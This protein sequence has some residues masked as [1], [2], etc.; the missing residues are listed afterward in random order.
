MEEKVTLDH[1]LA[2]SQ[3]V[4]FLLTSGARGADTAK[5]LEYLVRK[6]NEKDKEKPQKWVPLVTLR[7][8]REGA[9]NL[10]ALFFPTSGAPLELSN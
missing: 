9:L 7:S 5:K 8:I 3:Y 1:V 6:R 10:S 2:T 4:A